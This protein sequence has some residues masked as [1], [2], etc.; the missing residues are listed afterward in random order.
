MRLKIQF[1]PG[2]EFNYIVRRVAE[3]ACL[4]DGFDPCNDGI[5]T[6]YVTTVG[7]IRPSNFTRYRDV[8]SAKEIDE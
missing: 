4:L 8:L 1:E 6:A 3:N 2:T 7:D 5:P